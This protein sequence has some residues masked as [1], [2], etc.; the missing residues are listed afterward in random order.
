MSR[1]LPDRPNLEYLK[2]EAKALLVTMQQTD[3][4]AQLADAQ[5]AL[6]REYGFASWP[7]LKAHVDSMVAVHPLAGRWVAD[8]AQSKRHPA[9]RFQRATIDFAVNGNTV[10]ID[11]EF[12]DEAGAVIRNHNTIVADGLAHETPNGFVVTA[13]WRGHRALDTVATK[14]G[15]VEGRASY[16]VSTDGRTLTISANEGKQVIVLDRAAALSQ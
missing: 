6:A 9:N 5:H 13:T 3:A 7:K 12:V 2:K 16:A 8:V 14:N 15:E 1:N 10:D 11:D 4:A